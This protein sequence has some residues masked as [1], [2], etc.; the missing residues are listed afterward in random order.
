MLHPR[1]L[2]I[3]CKVADTGNMSRVAESEAK[4]IMAISKQVSR[5]EESLNQALFI[6]TRR[7]LVLTE[8]GRELKGKAEKLLEHYDAFEHWTRAKENTVTGE[9]RVVCQSNEIINET[10]IPWLA[11]FTEQYPDLDITLD[12]REQVIDILKDDFDIFWAVGSYLGDRYPGLKRKP[13]WKSV[14]GLFAS[15]EY[16]QSMGRPTKVEDL[17]SHKV[18]GYLHNQPS[19]VLVT[20][21]EKGE[22]KYIMPQCQIKTVTGMLELA[23]AGL[24][25]TNAPADT[26][27][28]KELLQKKRIEPV[29]QDYWWEDAEVYVY[30]HPSRPVQPKIRAFLDFFVEKRKEWRF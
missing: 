18:V 7:S 13:L 29:L 4:S 1:D 2:R 30:Y 26:E 9:L 16:L 23:E 15:P 12:V 5:L 24:G 11:E 10:L 14:Y 27:T 19:N 20:R 28:V 8:F 21:D 25:I 6:R 17:T 3:F 22:P